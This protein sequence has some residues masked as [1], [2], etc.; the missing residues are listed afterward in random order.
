MVSQASNGV[1]VLD[2]DGSFTYTPDANFNGSD[3]FTYTAFD[4]IGNSNVATV[5]LTVS[6][7]NDAPGATADSYSLDQDTTLSVVAPGVLGNDSDV[8]GDSITASLVTT[9]GNGSLTL[10][11]D[12]SFDYTPDPGFVGSDSF[13]YQADDGTIGGNTVTVSLTVNAVSPVQICPTAKSTS[14]GNTWQ[15]VNLPTRTRRWS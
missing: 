5:N 9:T 7:V 10:G 12:G 14:V 1:V 6:A 4:G 11:S 3:S 13:S 2:A 8:D 15:T